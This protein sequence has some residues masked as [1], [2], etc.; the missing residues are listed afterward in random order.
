MEKIVDVRLCLVSP[1]CM[2]S[3]ALQT[4]KL[5]QNLVGQKMW[6]FQYRN[7]IYMLWCNLYSER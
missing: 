1:E 7:H 3:T 4:Q 6:H 5:E 2:C